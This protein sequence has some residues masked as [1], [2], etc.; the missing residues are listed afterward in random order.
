MRILKLVTTIAAIAL[1][2]NAFAGSHYFKKGIVSS[3]D[4]QNE[5]FSVIDNDTGRTSVYNFSDDLTIKVNGLSYT[6][7]S[8]LEAGQKVTLKFRSNTTDSKT[9]SRE[10]ISSEMT[11]V[12]KVIEIN[13]SAGKGTLRKA[14]SNELIPFRF[15][16]NFKRSEMPN[17]GDDVIFTYKL[18]SLKVGMK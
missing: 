5:T 3:V 12:G 14:V 6:D 2:V 1:S 18:E 17:L 9:G 16:D 10:V 7:I 4:T 13:K 8:L 15:A 11:I